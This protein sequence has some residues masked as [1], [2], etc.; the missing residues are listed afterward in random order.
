MSRLVPIF[1]FGFLACSSDDEPVA[2]TCATS[3]CE[4][5]TKACLGH[6][7]ASCASD[8]RS[9]T[10]VACGATETCERD[11]CKPLVCLYRGQS[12]CDGTTKLDSC[13]DDGLSE[14]TVDCEASTETCKAGAC[15]QRACTPGSKVCGFREFAT[16]EPDG[17][18]WVATA[19]AADEICADGA[20]VKETCAP[21]ARKCS[22]ERIVGTC[23]ADGTGWVEVTCPEL[24]VCSGETLSCIPAICDAP[25]TDGTDATDGADGA[26]ADVTEPEDVVVPED[27]PEEPV[28]AGLKAPEKLIA[29][30]GGEE[31]KFKSGVKAFYTPEQELVITGTVGIKKIELHLK[32]IE[33]FAG[34]DF[35]D[36]VTSDTNVN[37]FYHDGSALIG[38]AQ[39]AYTS[40]AYNVSL[41]KFLAVGGR[42]QGTFECTLTDA[43]G[44]TTLE[45][46][47][48][49]FDVERD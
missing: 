10:Y 38:D 20:C 7:V 1:L 18:N 16:C 37:I 49:E 21:N 25:A 4:A 2:A 32:P 44:A 22:S 19:C 30:V 17:A 43:G 6:G 9:F 36:T 40:V 15:R 33:E 31:L 45:V 46:T 14:T 34:G 8:G 11:A 24:T 28:D 47:G 12:K 27:I 48:G 39:F 3:V 26:V 41:K 5:G 35:T 29:T 42:V 23:K 13:S